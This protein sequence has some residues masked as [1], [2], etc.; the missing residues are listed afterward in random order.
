MKKQVTVYVYMELMWSNDSSRRHWAPRVWPFKSDDTADSIFCH[1]QVLEVDVP[2]GFNPIPNQVAAIKE[3][4]AKMVAQHV[5]NLAAINE[6]LAK[7]LALT[8]EVTA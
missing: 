8:N 2:E 1:E 5:A 6:R 3:E 4:R 7:L